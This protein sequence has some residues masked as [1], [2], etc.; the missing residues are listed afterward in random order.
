VK[1]AAAVAE[2]LGAQ[3][4]AL[5]HISSN[6][7][8]TIIIVTL[9]SIT[10]TSYFI[11]YEHWFYRVFQVPLKIFDFFTTEDLEYLPNEVKPRIILCGY[12]RIGYSI[13]RSLQ[14]V[15]NKTLVVDYNPEIIAQLVK[16]GYHCLYGDVT[17]EQIIERMNLPQV[18]ML[19]STVPELTDNQL[20]IKKVQNANKRAKIIVTAAD[21][22]DALKL[23]HQGADYVILPHF[24]GGEH[25]SQLI[26]EVH[27]GK[28]TLHEEKKKHIFHLHE[29]R[30]L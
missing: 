11:K 13:L 10:F 2:A 28:R 18:Q 1:A 23:Y 25:V 7:F 3:G 29:R 19:I 17:D 26:N 5:G 14:H 22:D 30:M 12:N 4:L 16:E 24:L 21:I 27:D 20:L 9:I 6:L 8:S 15:K